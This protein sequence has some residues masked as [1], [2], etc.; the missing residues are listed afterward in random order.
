MFVKLHFADNC[1]F[2]KFIEKIILC[3][4]QIKRAFDTCGEM[5]KNMILEL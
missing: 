4:K 3:F 5:M 1:N 2:K